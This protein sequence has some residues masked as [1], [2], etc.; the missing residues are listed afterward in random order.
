MCPF[1]TGCCGT[2]NPPPWLHVNCMYPD[3]EVTIHY[4]LSV[5]PAV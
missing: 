3:T 4:Y 2:I 5:A 1:V